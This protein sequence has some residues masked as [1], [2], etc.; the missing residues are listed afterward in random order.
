MVTTNITTH[1]PE[2][3]SPDKLLPLLVQMRSDNISFPSLSEFKDYADEYGFGRRPELSSFA[4]L[5]GFL[6]QD[7]TDVY[8]RQTIWRGGPSSR[9][10]PAPPR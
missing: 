6:H 9:R 4:K 3:A 1:I 7:D 10:T 8:K 2:D 5:C